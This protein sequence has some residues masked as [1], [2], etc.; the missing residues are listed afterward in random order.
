MLMERLISISDRAIRKAPSVFSR[1]LIDDIDWS[2]QLIG[3]SGAR[4]S[5]KTILLLQYLKRLPKNTFALY[6]SLDDVYF[7]E[8]K[9]IYFAED[10][11]KKGGEYL[12]LDEI[13]KYPN[14]S[15]ELKNIYD[16]LPE[17][18][19]IFT[20]SSALEI[21]K[22]THDLSRRAVVYH[23][24]GLSFR[25][26]LELKYKIKLPKISLSEIL[27]SHN[28]LCSNILVSIKPLPLFDEY[29]KTGYYPFFTKTGSIYPR[30]LI[31]TVNLVVE[32]DLPAIHN[33]DFNSIIKI[34]KLLYVLSK[35]TPYSPNIEELAKQIGSTRDTLLRYLYYLDKAHIIKWLGR[36]KYGI[37]YL[38]K[39]DK[40]YLSNTNI[41]YA[42]GET[43]T[44]IGNVRETFFLNQ[45]S[46][47]HLVTYPKKADF[48]VDDKYYFEVGGKSKTKKQ[49][50]DLDD[51]F[52]AKDNIELG[53][54]NTIP[55]WLFGFM[56]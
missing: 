18:K 33:I 22:G 32:T 3:I 41:A 36:D 4:G 1:Y 35:K 14:W 26:F 20:S 27:T 25:E 38:N 2:H 42:L 21:Y 5:G 12:F 51:A 45:L 8:N 40:L 7:S 54:E 37:N 43:A 47:K 48:L 15:Q 29:L 30:Q 52:I 50:A 34:K 39:P 56:Y 16:N 46:I 53:F 44:D 11:H 31:N 10:F 28:E 23:L 24:F 19:V 13:H 55:L 9:L 17:L 49:I 6:A